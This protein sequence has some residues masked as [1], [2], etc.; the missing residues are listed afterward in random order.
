AGGEQRQALILLFGIDHTGATNASVRVNFEHGSVEEELERQFAVLGGERRL[1][2]V[3]FEL[4]ALHGDRQ[5][6]R[7]VLRPTQLQAESSGIWALELGRDLESFA[8]EVFDEVCGVSDF[9]PGK[10]VRLTSQFL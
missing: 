6:A 3:N 1:E 8:L 7:G 9:V 10:V 4:V 5:A 2:A